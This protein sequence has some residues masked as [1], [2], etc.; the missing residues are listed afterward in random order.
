MLIRENIKPNAFYSIQETAS[1]IGKS[2]RT[3]ERYN[4]S[5]KLKGCL[6]KMDNK[7]RFKG[8][9]ILKLTSFYN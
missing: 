2:T 8:T 3:V 4:K 6:S 1:I 5:G 9:E 7:W